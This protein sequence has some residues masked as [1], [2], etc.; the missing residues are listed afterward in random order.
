MT[1]IAGLYRYRLGDIVKCVGY[2]HQSPIVEF[3]YRQGSL[4][5]LTGEKVS[6]K[7]VFTAITEA[8][9]LIGDDYQV[10]EYTTRIDFSSFPGRYVFYVE[11]SKI[12]ESPPELKRC[13]DK[14]EEVISDFNISYMKCRQENRIG[15]LELKLMNKDCFKKLKNQ[16]ILPG[17]SDSQFKMPRHLKDS[18]LVEFLESMVVD[19]C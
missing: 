16:M 6:E 19:Q 3:L 9:K 15:Q 18:N 5:N 10:I 13:R 11:T 8:I 1:T 17:Y 12:L 2:Y 4:L 7:T 14:M